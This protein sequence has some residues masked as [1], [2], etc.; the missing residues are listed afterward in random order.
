MKKS[1][2]ATISLVITII[3]GATM[4]FLPLASA[5]D[6]SWTIDTYAYLSVQPNPI[7]VNQPV[8]VQMWINKVPPGST[9]PWGPRPA[10]GPSPP[11]AERRTASW[12]QARLRIGGPP[13]TPGV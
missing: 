10:P 2:I 7:G 12:S 4:T 11:A 13:S 6:P 8:F 1:K 9:G 3:L 5:H